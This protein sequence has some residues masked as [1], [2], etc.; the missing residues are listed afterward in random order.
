MVSQLRTLEWARNRLRKPVSEC[1]WLHYQGL[2]RV[3]ASTVLETQLIQFEPCIYLAV[4]FCW[5]T[6]IPILSAGFPESSSHVAGT[7]GTH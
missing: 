5:W 7:Y 6:T 1:V 2:V 4:K 3:F